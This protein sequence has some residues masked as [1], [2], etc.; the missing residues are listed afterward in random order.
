MEVSTFLA[1]GDKERTTV[2]TPVWGYIL[3][4]SDHETGAWLKALKRKYLDY[5]FQSG[6]EA[7]VLVMSQPKHW[8]DKGSGRTSGRSSGCLWGLGTVFRHGHLN[9]LLEL[10]YWMENLTIATKHNYL[11]F[12]GNSSII[13]AVMLQ[14]L[15]HLN[16][17]LSFCFTL[18]CFYL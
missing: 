3:T 15:R 11:Q 13:K 7:A 2:L 14:F 16:Y 12:R 9:C 10:T 4:L 6:S 1:R 5:R 8:L 17:R 18:P